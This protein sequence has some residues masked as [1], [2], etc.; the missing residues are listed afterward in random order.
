MII[1]K[2]S[3]VY[4]KKTH[5]LATAYRKEIHKQIQAYLKV[6]TQDILL[7]GLKKVKSWDGYDG[8]TKYY[9][10]C[11]VLDKVIAGNV[12]QDKARE[13]YEA[14]KSVSQNMKLPSRMERERAALEA[15][16]YITNFELL[17]Q[18]ALFFGRRVPAF[19]DL[20]RLKQYCL[21]VVYQA[22]EERMASSSR[23][24]L[25]EALEFAQK[26][27]KYYPSNIVQGKILE[28]KRRLPC[29]EC[30]F[31]GKCVHCKGK[32]GKL[33]LCP[34]CRGNQ[35]VYTKCPV[36]GPYGEGKRGDGKANCSQCAGTGYIGVPCQ[37]CNG[38]GRVT[39]P[40]C[41]GKGFFV[42]KC[43]K[44]KGRKVLPC[45]NCYGK[46]TVIAPNGRPMICPVCKGRKFFSCNLCKGTG[47]LRY[48]CE[49]SASLW[50]VGIF[51]KN[52]SFRYK[53]C[54]GQ[55]TV[56]CPQCHGTLKVRT[57]CPQCQ[58][59]RRIGTCPKCNGAGRIIVPC[60]T[61]PPEHKGKIFKS[62]PHC[63]GTGVCPVCK[64]VGHRV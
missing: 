18:Q 36:C 56:P 59:A 33:Y 12:I 40:T 4:Q 13:T 58:G 26:S 54:N 17:K 25:E 50:L 43:R 14:L 57:I 19:K 63:K 60:P 22:I 24:E 23:K 7:A 8:G 9:F 34:T 48:R 2:V 11:F 20:Q 41:K 10:A 29:I 16:K 6:V 45:G 62:C 31:T 52:P 28:I 32:R 42:G 49:P 35:R 61:C 27:L 64:G 53:F 3:S 38:V 51:L 37:F 39:C 15:L 47:I 21:R 30:G 44:C 46:G 1:A 5:I 55:G